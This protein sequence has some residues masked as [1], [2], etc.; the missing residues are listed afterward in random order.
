MSA[1]RVRALIAVG[2]LA[3][4]AETVIIIRRIIP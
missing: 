1:G 2:I 3:N 4:I